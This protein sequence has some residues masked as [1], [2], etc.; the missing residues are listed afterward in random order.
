MKPQAIEAANSATKAILDEV[1][2]EL[3]VAVELVNDIEEE[4]G[5]ESGKSGKPFQALQHIKSDDF[6]LS[7][8][9]A[10]KIRAIYK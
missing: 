3:G 7:D 5:Y 8:S 10:N 4:L 9:F 1:I 6:Q 2:E